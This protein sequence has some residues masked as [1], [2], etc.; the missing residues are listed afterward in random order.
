MFVFVFLFGLCIGSFLNVCIRR[1][2][3]QEGLS[4]VFPASHC[5]TCKTPIKPYDNIPVF[6]YLILA[7]KCRACRA[8]IS[9]VYPLVEMLTALLFVACYPEFGPSFAFF[10]WVI[11]CSLIVVLVFTD[12]FDRIL[13][14]GVNF[15]G[16]ALALVFSFFS[17]DLGDSTINLI[18][19]FSVSTPAPSIW[20]NLAG[21]LLG[22]AFGYGLL[23]SFATVYRKVTGRE[24]MGMGDWKMMAMVGAFLG[25]Q[26][27]FMTIFAGTLLGSTIGSSTILI[28]FLSG[29]KSDVAARAHRRGL[30]EISRLR[31]VRA[32]RY[33]LPLGTFLGAGAILVVFFGERGISWYLRHSGIK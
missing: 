17:P 5:M 32:S 19:Q 11:F 1:I 30:G 14:D 6:S 18:S 25:P 31:F 12:I 23:W 26:F 33:W 15:L 22:A 4:I 27:T 28:L 8:P 3:S 2:P 10:K 16:L 24:G 9:I 13:P 29:W 21:A 7:G 20:M